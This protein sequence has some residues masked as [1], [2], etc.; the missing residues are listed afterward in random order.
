MWLSCAG[1]SKRSRILNSSLLNRFGRWFHRPYMVGRRLLNISVSMILR[2]CIIFVFYISFACAT[3]DPIVIHQQFIEEFSGFS[4]FFIVTL[5]IKTSLNITK[6]SFIDYNKPPRFNV[7]SLS[8]ERWNAIVAT[9]KRVLKPP[10]IKASYKIKFF[11]IS[12]VLCQQF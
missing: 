6:T 4:D 5:S 2:I 7:L 1:I 11:Q 8:K 10:I 12:F 3:T 9:S